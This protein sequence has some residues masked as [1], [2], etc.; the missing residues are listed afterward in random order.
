MIAAILLV[1]RSA[2]L[3]LAVGALALA[4]NAWQDNRMDLRA[5]LRPDAMASAFLGLAAWAALSVLWQWAPGNALEQG[6]SMGGIL[7]LAWLAAHSLPAAGSRPHADLVTAIFLGFAIGVTLLLVELASDHWLHRWLYNA[8]PAFRPHESEFIQRDGLVVKVR[9]E[10]INRSV[11]VAALLIWPVL[12]L[13][14]PRRARPSGML[15]ALGLL[16]ATAL[17]VFISRHESSKLALVT[18]L[19]IAALAAW[20]WQSAYRCTVGIWIVLC[21]LCVPIAQAAFHAKLYENSSLQD[22]ARARLILWGVAANKIADAPL[23][24]IGAGAGRVLDDQLGKAEILPGQPYELRTGSH[25]HNVYLQAWYELGAVGA[26]LLALAGGLLISRSQ[27]V[28]VPFRP[29]ALAAI[30]AVAVMASVSYGLWQAWFQALIVW[31]LLVALL[32]TT[33]DPAKEF[34]AKS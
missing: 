7:L 12:G 8:V 22:S 10:Q 24:G 33:P 13:L 31:S 16:A 14:W 32:W 27:S 19:A 34:T 28:P 23:L 20:S 21:L 18:S 17:V 9:F 2:P 3:M 6:A 4:A 29:H 11:A 15:T 25:Q 1:P 5:L 30:C 26:L